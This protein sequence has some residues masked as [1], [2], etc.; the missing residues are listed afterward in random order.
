MHKMLSTKGLL[1][2]KYSRYAVGIV[3]GIPLVAGLQGAYFL[4][5]FRQNHKDAPRPA[6][7]SRGLVI[8]SPFDNLNSTSTTELHDETKQG[9]D[10]VGII[11]PSKSTSNMISVRKLS[12]GRKNMQGN[13]QSNENYQKPTWW[14]YWRRRQSMENQIP[15]SL[16]VVG[17]S[18]AAGVG[19]TSGT[20]KLPEAIARSLS[21]ALG[22]R[23]V[24]WTCHG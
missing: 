24:Y 2:S 13:L 21:K 8:V 16:L 14:S 15:L 1:Q 10:R 5:K 4:I 18:L 23:P 7:P 19:S 12:W 6:S 9:H 20:P 3:T 22:G 17:D 11:D